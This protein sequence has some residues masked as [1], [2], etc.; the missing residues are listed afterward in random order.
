MEA[1]K[2]TTKKKYNGKPLNIV[3]PWDEFE[4]LVAIAEKDHR[5]IA[6]TAAMFISLELQ[7]RREQ[8]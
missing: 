4:E 3:V 8:K 1:E 2:K 7:R 6:G 5:S